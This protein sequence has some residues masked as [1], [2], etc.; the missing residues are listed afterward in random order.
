VFIT[1]DLEDGFVRKLLEDFTQAATRAAPGLPDGEGPG[2]E[3]TGT[4]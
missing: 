3:P 1:A 2:E 4:P